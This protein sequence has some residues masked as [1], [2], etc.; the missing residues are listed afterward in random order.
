MPDDHLRLI[1]TFA[2]IF[3]A[4]ASGMRETSPLNREVGRG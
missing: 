4:S 1:E 3:S 2:F